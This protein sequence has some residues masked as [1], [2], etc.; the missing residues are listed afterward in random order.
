VNSDIIQ[1]RYD[2]L[3]RVAARFG[4]ASAANAELHRRI[5]RCV[6]VLERGGWQGRG[7]DA[8][9]A[10]MRG[11]LYP[12]MQRLV[13]A[14]DE[15]RTVTLEVKNII[16]RAEEEAAALFGNRAQ[17]DLGIVESALG[18]LLQ[19]SST[20]KPSKPLSESVQTLVTTLGVISVAADTIATSLS[21]A[22]TIVEVGLALVDGPAP[23]GDVVGLA[24]YYTVI[25]PIE[26]TVSTIGLGSTVI[27]DVIQGNTYVDTNSLELVIGQDTLVGGA[28]FL[29]GLATEGIVDTGLNAAM[30]IYD[31]RSLTGDPVTF[32]G[33]T[34][35]L[36]LSPR[37]PYFVGYPPEIEGN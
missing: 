13:K 2:D 9:F 12:A 11:T 27:S 5:T 6:E 29:V 17:D 21:A 26:N 32:G 15:G 34:W 20:P 36:R 3:D 7:A 16:K 18:G 10:E 35:E 22:G 19:T 1:S 23:V 8:F 14:L 30:L 31:T 25:N 28:G 33:H 4:K 37:G 24:G